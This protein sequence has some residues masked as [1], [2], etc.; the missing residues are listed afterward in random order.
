MR[1]PPESMGRITVH[2]SL[3]RLSK[4]GM[5][6]AGHQSIR[7]IALAM[8]GTIQGG[9]LAPTGH[10]GW[11]NRLAETEGTTDSP[12]PVDAHLLEWILAPGHGQVQF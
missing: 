5:T 6:P 4:T 1:S 12:H 8:F 7:W 11:I 10:D 2:Q 3:Q 9:N